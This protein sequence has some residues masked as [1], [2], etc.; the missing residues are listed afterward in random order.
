[1]S[2]LLSGII[3]GIIGGITGGL[4]VYYLKKEEYTWCDECRELYREIENQ[5]PLHIV[6]AS[7]VLENEEVFKKAEE[8]VKILNTLEHATKVQQWLKSAEETA[9]SAEFALVEH[10]IAHLKFDADSV[11]YVIE[12]VVAL[13]INYTAV[14][15]A[16]KFVRGE[17]FD[18]A[19]ICDEFD[20]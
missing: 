20:L 6:I 1:M 7:S 15:I 8:V 16:D 14:Y 10:I 4:T 3:G 5:S 13:F 19:E 9:L 11:M 12:I 18:I 17:D 2:K